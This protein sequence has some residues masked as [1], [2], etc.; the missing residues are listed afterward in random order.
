MLNRGFGRAGRYNRWPGSSPG[1]TVTT[2]TCPC[3][4]FG[5]RI[6]AMRLG[7]RLTITTVFCGTILCCSWAQAGP[8]LHSDSSAAA[9]T[10]ASQSVDAN[11]GR[12]GERAPI[13]TEDDRLSL[14][15]AALDR[16]VRMHSEP[17]CSHLVHAI[18][19]QAGFS[20]A[21]AS[22]SDLYA[23]VGQFQRIK[24]PQ[25]GDLIVW[26]GHVGMV[27]KPS[28][29]IFF[30]FLRSGPGTDD[31]ESPYWKSRGHPR[32]Y[33]YV[34]NGSCDG[35]DPVRQDSNRFLRIKKTRR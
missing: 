1:T 31:Y 30:S 19:Q 10:A 6:E 20:Y 8:Q 2:V 13:L 16:R 35:C 15:A 33:R 21:Y 7:T 29:H 27:I 24:Q 9:S 18:Y 23:G 12:K 34:K 11:Q 3:G 25:P 4:E 22:S 26:R 5:I 32:F 28:E 17:D 14:L